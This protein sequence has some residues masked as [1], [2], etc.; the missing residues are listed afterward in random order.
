MLKGFTHARLAMI[1]ERQVAHVQRQRAAGA[2][3]F[4]HDGDRAALDA[5]AEADAAAACEA[6]VR[7]PFQHPEVIILQE[8]LDLPIDLLL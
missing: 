8:R 3:L 2:F 6:R 1:E 5:F 7:E 4:D